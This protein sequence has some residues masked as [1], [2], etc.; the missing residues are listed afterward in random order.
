MLSE[1]L[2]ASYTLA[3]QLA[4]NPR[5]GLYIAVNNCNV[6]HW[7][8]Q[9]PRP[10]QLATPPTA[11]PA[12]LS[13]PASNVRVRCHVPVIED[14]ELVRIIRLFNE[15]MGKPGPKPVLEWTCAACAGTAPAARSL[16]FGAA[17]PGSG[18]VSGS[19]NRTTHPQQA[20]LAA[21]S[22]AKQASTIVIDSDDDDEIQI[23]ENDAKTTDIKT[24]IQSPRPPQPQAD[25]QAQARPQP[26]IHV[27]APIPHRPA[28]PGRSAKTTQP[29]RSPGLHPAPSTAR[30]SNDSAL[31]TI[32]RKTTIAPASSHNAVPAASPPIARPSAIAPSSKP[33]PIPAPLT[34]PAVRPPIHLPS[35]TQTPTIP[36]RA[37]QA[38]KSSSSGPAQT[39]HRNGPLSAISPALP[40]SIPAPRPSSKVQSTRSPP[41][42]AADMRWQAPH[43]EEWEDRSQEEEE[44]EISVKGEDD[45][46]EDEDEIDELEDDDD[47]E[48]GDGDERS[49]TQTGRKSSRTPLPT[50]RG[51]NAFVVPNRPQASPPPRRLPEWI[52]A[53]YDSAHD[54]WARRVI[55]SHSAP[56]SNPSRR[57]GGASNSELDLEATTRTTTPTLV[58]SS[59][60]RRRARKAFTVVPLNKWEESISVTVDA[61]DGLKEEGKEKET[62]EKEGTAQRPTRAALKPKPNRDSF[63]FAVDPWM[64]TKMTELGV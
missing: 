30:P 15:R 63:F 17:Q 41:S 47:D 28:P 38:A 18:S 23:I 59:K 43:I 36:A 37:Q 57:D 1:A 25:P 51:A 55:T 53:R 31:P 2:V 16:T 13:S 44:E 45:S 60:L 39:G 6:R 29:A 22:S 20:P 7:T 10:V 40:Q 34:N 11:P 14:K 9:W 8:R 26:Q 24:V 49:K 64:L 46:D 42:G 4:L 52:N 62:L 21:T 48:G 32:A 33:T 3:P 50:N 61:K 58:P 27:P 12:T 56:V 35:Q 54:I 5:R 19:S